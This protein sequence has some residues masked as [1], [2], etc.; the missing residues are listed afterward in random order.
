M[1]GVVIPAELFERHLV[2]SPAAK[3]MAAG[4]E[5]QCQPASPKQ[6]KPSDSYLRVL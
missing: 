4:D 2:E 1:F 6:A 5:A 3:G